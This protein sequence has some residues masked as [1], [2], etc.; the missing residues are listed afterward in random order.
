MLTSKE[1][2]Y[3][4]GLANSI[5]TIFQIG[6]DGIS[7]NLE[8]QVSEALE[9]RELVKINVLNN[10]LLE[11]REVSRQL[12]NNIH[13]ELVQVIGNKFILY[14]QSRKNQEIKLPR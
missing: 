5:P 7:P 12:A 11:P 1:R 14:K 6:K 8:Q 9:A 2:A 10:N 3:L 4:R 13:A